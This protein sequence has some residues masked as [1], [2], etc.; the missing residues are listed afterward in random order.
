L[1]RAVVLKDA[2]L[3]EDADANFDELVEKAHRIARNGG[4]PEG[5][6]TDE[7]PQGRS[8]VR[9][10][11]RSSDRNSTPPRRSPVKK[12]GRHAR[13]KSNSSSSDSGRGCRHRRHST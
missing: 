11:S 4:L 7:P 6:Q 3:P 12:A 8:S 9:T 13:G 10:R 5:L 2:A 1:A